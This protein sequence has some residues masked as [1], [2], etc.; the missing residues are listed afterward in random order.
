MFA[1]P[2][3]KHRRCSCSWRRGSDWMGPISIPSIGCAVFA[4]T[5][6]RQA[7]SSCS[8]STASPRLESE[9]TETW[10][11]IQTVTLLLSLYLGGRGKKRPFLQEAV[12]CEL[13]GEDDTDSGF[14]FFFLLRLCEE[15]AP[16]RERSL[17]SFSFVLN[18]NAQS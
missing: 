17:S 4:A 13:L 2:G 7:C 9:A 10:R 1:P 16:R 18:G 11:R 5:E 15:V 6:P 3:V 8:S 14:F 12:D